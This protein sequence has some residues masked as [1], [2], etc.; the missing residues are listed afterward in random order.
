MELEEG[1]VAVF[2]DQVSV[3]RWIVFNWN[4]ISHPMVILTQY[5]SVNRWIVFNWNQKGTE[6]GVQIN[7]FQLIVG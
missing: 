6:E 2:D 1:E 5:V 3:N 4:S 7:L